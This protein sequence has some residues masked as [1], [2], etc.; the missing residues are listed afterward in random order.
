MTQNLLLSI[1][2]EQAFIFATYNERGEI[3]QQ[4]L[5]LQEID[6]AEISEITALFPG[7]DS[8]STTV[9]MPP[10]SF[11]QLQKALPY[12]LEDNLISDIK[13]LQFIIKPT[14][15]K[16]T[17]S[18]NITDK[19]KL[20]DFLAKLAEINIQP[21]LILPNYL[22]LPYVANTWRVVINEQKALVRTGINT[23]FTIE[24]ELL[25]MTLNKLFADLAEPEK[26]TEIF[27]HVL[28]NA[29][30]IASDTLNFKDLILHIQ[31]ERSLIELFI[32]GLSKNQS[33]INLITNPKRSKKNNSQQYKIWLYALAIPVIWLTF[34]L[35]SNLI[36]FVYLNHKNQQYQQKINQSY[37]AIFP[38]ATSVVAPE[39]RV[40]QILQQIQSQQ[41][42]QGFLS[43]MA[44][45][46]TVLA[47]KPIQ[48]INFSYLNNILYLSL[49]TVNANTLTTIENSLQQAGF[50][51]VLKQ[52]KIAN[53]T[54]AQFK[55]MQKSS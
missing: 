27:W 28:N 13:D 30:E 6:S 46:T 42:D 34:F 47:N 19:A 9:T 7:T 41:D 4:A 11:T 8:I 44:K 31:E 1:T 43:L 15:I 12:A 5:S 50:F 20:Q 23:G 18:A 33:Q 3:L 37:Y 2:A 38:Q 40:Q 54:V 14:A 39:F 21:N 52:E 24:A 53:K 35:M 25:L 36:S 29:H 45:V 17:Y 32:L 10:I 55:I 49:S 26:P 48:L 22:A 16:N 51:C